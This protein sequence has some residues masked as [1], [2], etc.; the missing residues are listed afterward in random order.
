M[1]GSI[2]YN[3][4]KGEATVST[5]RDGHRKRMDVTKTLLELGLNDPEIAQTLGVSRATVQTDRRLMGIVR[6]EA[7]DPKEHFSYLV[8]AYAE[9][10]AR[11]YVLKPDLKRGFETALRM[12]EVLAALKGAKAAVVA[13]VTQDPGSEGYRKLLEA[14]F[15]I[16]AIRL[17]AYEPEDFFRDYCCKLYHHELTVP[18]SFGALCADVL[19]VYLAE[20]VIRTKPPWTNETVGLATQIIDELIATLTPR[21]AQILEVRFGLKGELKTLVQAGEHFGIASERVRQIEAQALRKLKHHSRSSYLQ[22]LTESSAQL[23]KWDLRQT[24][25]AIHQNKVQKLLD[26]INREH[27]S[28]NFTTA[29]FQSLAKSVDE[30][31]ITV[32]SYNCLKNANIKTIWELVQK[33]EAD[34]LKSRWFGRKS[35]QEI[36]TILAAM[37]LHLDMQFDEATRQ[38]YE[39]LTKR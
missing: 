23:L 4:R 33:N 26:E 10:I 31:E 3:L 36:K 12:P 32:R 13:P 19:A 16:Q 9:S 1:K 39:I 17:V 11:N 21:E 22:I 6:K 5:P 27:R 37:G 28:I 20:E 34:M 2:L 8:S 29:Q 25:R 30:I 35:I 7:W 38:A 18:D 15:G 24:L 14:I